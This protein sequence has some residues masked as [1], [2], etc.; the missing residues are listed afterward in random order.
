MKTYKLQVINRN[1]DDRKPGKLRKDGLIPAT[2]Y[3]KN[4]ENVSVAVS[5]D[6]FE[7]L[8]SQA[9]ETGVIEISVGSEK[10]PV[11]IHTVQINPVTN[12]ILNVEFR[13]VDL[14]VKVR[15]NIPISIIGVSEAV[16]QKQ[17]MLLELINEVEVEALPTDLP[18]NIKVD[19]STLKAVNEEIKVGSMSLPETVAMV[20]DPEVV[21]VRIGALV[22][23]IEEAPAVTTTAEPTDENAEPDSAA[24]PENQP[25]ESSKTDAS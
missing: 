12:E 16:Q 6:E 13:Q 18:E 22:T 1:T 19:V 7:N 14:K 2:I 25:E 11:L 3:G 10:K 4:V 9:G 8:Y 21:I 5:T 17:G 23:E 24:Q 15:A 20:T